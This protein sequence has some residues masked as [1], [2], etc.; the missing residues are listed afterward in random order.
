MSEAYYIEYTD[1]IF[2]IYS[3][4]KNLDKA[5]QLYNFFNLDKDGVGIQH[6]R[7]YIV[8]GNISQED[9]YLISEPF[10][11][12]KVEDDYTNLYNK[13]FL[14]FKVLIAMYPNCRGVIKCD[15][16]I[17]LNINSMNYF[18]HIITTP[19]IVDY[20]IQ[21]MGMST[22]TFVVINKLSISFFF[23][24]GPLYYI[25]NECMCIISLKGD[26]SKS[27]ADISEFPRS[28]DLMIG[29]ALDYHNIVPFNLHPFSDSIHDYSRV[30][31][32]NKYHS[33]VIFC[34]LHGGLGNILFQSMSAYFVGRRNNAHVFYI[35]SEDKAIYTHT[36]GGDSKSAYLDTILHK[37]SHLCILD[38]QVNVSAISMHFSEVDGTNNCFAYHGD[39][40]S[41]ALN[42]NDY[43]YMYGYFQNERY[44]KDNMDDIRNLLICPVRSAAVNALYPDVCNSYFIHVRRGDYVNNIPYMIDYT[45]YFTCA[46]NYII[47]YDS[48][49]RF[50]IFS[51]DIDF[52]RTYPALEGARNAG[53][54]MVIL[55]DVIDTIY[56]MSLCRKGGICSNSTFSWWGNYLNVY[57]D[58]LSIFPSKWMS[59]EDISCG[60]YPENA[61]IITA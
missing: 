61:I 19:S 23:C 3:C 56:L 4:K 34:R 54:T 33:K 58:K 46:I 6:C 52:C 24:A 49:A 25:N 42:A 16:D 53:A 12:L 17:I 55:E 11:S 20:T 22:L 45:A 7:G 28:E 35:Y 36:K 41:A 39:K 37:I 5:I 30:S 32:H 9:E 26:M 15:D 44:F 29:M 8:Y 10:I 18:L 47:K 43:L 31:F 48:S 51:D 59:G 27:L 38:T 60:I 13:S 40:I 1:Y 57:P 2:I 14:L 21:Y 50:Y